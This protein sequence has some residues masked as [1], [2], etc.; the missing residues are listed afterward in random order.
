[1]PGTTF[2]MELDEALAVVAV[3]ATDPGF[4][5][6]VSDADRRVFQAEARRV[7]EAHAHEAARRCLSPASVPHLRLVRSPIGDDHDRRRRRDLTDGRG[8]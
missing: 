6:F 8:R 1:M 7:V 2:E 4:P 3:I 5:E